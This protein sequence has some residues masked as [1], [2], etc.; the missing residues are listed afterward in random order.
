MP[1]K[2]EKC[3]CAGPVFATDDK[4]DFKMRIVAKRKNSIARHNRTVI[5]EQC[6]G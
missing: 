3:E 5:C 4:L 6:G 2:E 1:N